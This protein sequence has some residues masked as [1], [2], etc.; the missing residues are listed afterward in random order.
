[1]AEYHAG[2][3]GGHGG[4]VKIQKRIGEVFFWEGMMTDIKRF[5]A[6]C[7]VCQRQKYSTLAPGGLLNH[8]QYLSRFGRIS[9]W[10]SSKA[11]LVLKGKTLYWW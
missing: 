7:A 8:C 1:M 5:V 3:L 2:K 6:S 11:F 10:T 9:P 4:V